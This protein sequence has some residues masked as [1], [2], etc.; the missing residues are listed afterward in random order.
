[1]SGINV[2]LIAG[3]GESSFCGT[4]AE[5]V[6]ESWLNGIRVSVFDSLDELPP[7]GE[8]AAS[9]ELPGSVDALRNAA[10]AAD[11][12]LLV[13]HYY[14]LVPATVHNAIDWLTMRWNDSELHEKP[15]AVMGYSADCYRGV[16]SHCQSGR[17][18]EISESR[19]IESITVD[20]LREAVAKLAGEVSTVG[21]VAHDFARDTHCPPPH[22]RGADV[23]P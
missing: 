18:G 13:T 16:W 22:H 17:R 3:N 21:E 5:L 12:V 6:G 4:L 8:T 2:L 11:A 1:M 14:A 9:V 20:S 7:F 15:L 23:V 10:A 19:I